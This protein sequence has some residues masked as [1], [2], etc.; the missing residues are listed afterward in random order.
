MVR[1]F[2]HRVELDGESS[3]FLRKSLRIKHRHLVLS[4][5]VKFV[6]A[7]IFRG[8]RLVSELWRGQKQL[9]VGTFDQILFVFQERR[10]YQF[11]FQWID[12]IDFLTQKKLL[13]QGW[14]SFLLCVEWLDRVFLHLLRSEET[15]ILTV[16]VVA[17][18][19]GV[20]DSSLL[21][22]AVDGV[23]CFAKSAIPNVASPA[24]FARSHILVS[25]F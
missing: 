18:A 12:A 4:V 5:L 14:W 21:L 9:L 6:Q 8:K 13:V 23:F 16:I 2:A 10:L 17:V 11:W 24:R 15:F 25:V 19:T 22:R 20:H 3:W 7:P 1:G